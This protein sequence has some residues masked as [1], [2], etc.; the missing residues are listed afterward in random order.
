MGKELIPWW[1]K[2][3]FKPDAIEVIPNG[4]DWARYQAPPSMEGWEC[5][6][7]W[8]EAQYRLLYIGRITPEKG[9]YTHLFDALRLL[10]FKG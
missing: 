4:L 7:A 5:P 10:P 3:G 2:V 6:P 1:R 9:G 8:S